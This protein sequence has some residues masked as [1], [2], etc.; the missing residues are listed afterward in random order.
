[1]S[2]MGTS[3][4]RVEADQLIDFVAEQLDSNRLVVVRRVDLD[5][6]AADAEHAAR[7]LMVVP[8]V[9]DLDEL[10]ENLGSVDTLSALEWQ[11]HAVIR[12]RGPQP[13]DTRHTGDNEDVA[14]LEESP[15]RREP[16]AVDLVVDG[17]FFLNVRIGGRDVRFRLVVV[18]VAD[19]VLDRVVGK[20]ALELLVELGSQRLI[21]HHHQSR[22]VH[23]GDDVRHRERLPR[24]GYPEEHLV[25][26][27]ALKSFAQLRD[28]ALL[29]A[30]ELEI[31]HER[32]SVVGRRHTAGCKSG[33]SAGHRTTNRRGRCRRVS[34]GGLL[35]WVVRWCR[36]RPRSSPSGFGLSRGASHGESAAVRLLAPAM[37]HP[38]ACSSI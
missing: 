3:S 4:D 37:S 1:M 34:G 33:A 16:H 26:V 7:E 17:R 5:D 19:E 25:L 32:E 13:I 15:R 27:A 23:C 9:L 11:Q 8:L 6:V 10:P 2:M 38:H 28:R 20:K 35:A 21:V 29:V 24:P 12:L 14:A 22:S 30:P 18:V 36:G 31:G